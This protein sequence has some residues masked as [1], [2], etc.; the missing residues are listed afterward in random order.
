ME[1]NHQ[2]STPSID[3]LAPSDR[4]ASCSQ[5]HGR[6]QRYRLLLRKFWWVVGLILV[7]VLGPVYLITA[8]LPPAYKSSARLWL[9]GRVNIGDGRL[10]TEELIDYLATQTELLRSPTIQ[11]RALAKLWAQNTNGLPLASF[12][13][14]KPRVG[15]VH[16]AMAFV[17]SLVGRGSTNTTET[18]FPFVVKANES[19]KSSTLE[20]QVTGNDR[21][22]TRGFLNCLIEEYFAFKKETREKAFNQTLASVSSEAHGLRDGLKAQQEKLHAFQTSNNVVFLQE[23][24]SSDASYLA[25]LN[26]QIAALHT[27]LQ[28]LERLEP[29]QWIDVESRR[30]DLNS[31]D[32]AEASGPQTLAGLAGPQADLFKARQ[33]AQLLRAKRD[34]L[35]RFLRPLHPKILKLNEELAT[36][37][38]IMDVSRDEA[39]QQLNN[40]RQALQLQIK[41]LEAAFEEWDRKAIASSRKLADYDNLRLDLQRLQAADDRMLGVIQTV[42]VSKTVDQENVGVLQLASVARPVQR[43][44]INM[45]CALI[46]GLALS[47]AALYCLGRFDDRFVS[48]IE[49]AGCLGQQVLGQIPAIPLRRP[50]GEFGIQFLERQRFE[51]LESF[52]N[53]RSALLF[54]PNG[55]ARPKTILIS[56]SLPREGKSTVAF[57]LAATMAMT[58]SR[59]L[60]IDA[61]MRRPMLH[62]FL[63]AAASPGLAEIL[64]EEVSTARAIVPSCLENLH[65]LPAGVARR[66]P[67]ELVLSPGW[68]DLMAAI[69]PQ[70][71][72][73][74][75]D[76]PPLLAT[77]DAASLAPKADGVL[78]IVRSAFTS[79]RMARR[80]VDLLMQRRAHVLGLVFNRAAILGNGYHQYEHFQNRYRWRPE[81]SSPAPALAYEAKSSKSRLAAG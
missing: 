3:L 29:E 72:Y 57:Y 40:R 11:E 66:N 74:L 2:L 64:S 44:A 18:S 9:T 28:L 24:G 25:L 65:L 63:A 54:M 34:E 22:A 4:F 50:A 37:E 71:D 19:S 60:L 70:F 17:K 13:G 30:R 46:A 53:L 42:D 31:A 45:A 43:M 32:P 15:P 6:I 81:P 8:E 41:N 56:S 68:N 39:L 33:Q 77:D 58:R 7:V 35:S 36:Q 1:N 55:E 62:E 21:A 78:M 26:K 76:S 16:R 80:G 51:F 23:Q 38:K 61:D 27:E 49:L 12:S 59:V 5:F 67:G 73:V 20:L 14:T 47:F 10:Y 79:A 48:P 52:R 69:Y 75:I